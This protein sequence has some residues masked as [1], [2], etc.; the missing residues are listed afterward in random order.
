[1]CV[2]FDDKRA[3]TALTHN[4]G[5]LA[6]LPIK[7]MWYI[8]PQINPNW[9][10]MVCDW[11]IQMNL[12]WEEYDTMPISKFYASAERF[13]Y[14]L[15]FNNLSG[16]NKPFTLALFA[17][18]TGPSGFKALCSTSWATRKLQEESFWSTAWQTVAAKHNTTDPPLPVH[19]QQSLATQIQRQSTAAKPAEHLDQT[20]VCLFVRACVCVWGAGV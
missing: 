1:M 10:V 19:W 6:P 18:K 20:E 9:A 8:L 11:R 12:V 16:W 5:L 13:I 15:S 3:L 17:V 14:Q 7:G 4:T 2:N